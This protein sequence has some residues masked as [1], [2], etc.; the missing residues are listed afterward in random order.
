ME[1]VCLTCAACAFLVSTTLLS[2]L[3]VKFALKRHLPGLDFKI[4]QSY[5]GYVSINATNISDDKKL[6]FFYTPTDSDEGDDDVVIW[7]N[8][9]PGCS[10]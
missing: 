6:Y 3:S 4:P 5:G 2:P 8:G 9:G 1:R 7:L 10:A